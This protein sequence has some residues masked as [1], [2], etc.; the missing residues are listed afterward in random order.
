MKTLLRHVTNGRTAPIHDHIK[1]RTSEM[2]YIPGVVARKGR[3]LGIP[4]PCNDAVVALDR[5]INQGRLEMDRSNFERLRARIG[6]A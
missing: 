2:E 6:E 3:A 4:T 1:G 5:E